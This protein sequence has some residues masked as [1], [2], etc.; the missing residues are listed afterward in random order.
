ML[1]YVDMNNER[2]RACTDT[3][4]AMPPMSAYNNFH[5]YDVDHDRTEASLFAD[6]KIYRPGQTVHVAA[7]V[8]KVEGLT[9]KAVS[10]KQIKLT[11]RDANYK[12]V[13]EKT[14]TTDAYGTASTDFMLPQGGLTGSFTVRTDTE[15]GRCCVVPRGGI[16]ASY[17]R[18]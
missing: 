8:C 14:V 3:D 11:L 2:I 10:G 15:P 18:G 4:N 7:I 1:D 12:V 6:R 17:V 9:K 16:Q 5:K 13:D